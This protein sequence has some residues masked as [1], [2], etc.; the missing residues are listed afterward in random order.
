MIIND[1]ATGLLYSTGLDTDY[2]DTNSIHGST[3]RTLKSR[4]NT[5]TN[6][7]TTGAVSFIDTVLR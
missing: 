3:N 7:T 1:S 5:A 6:G 4:F 2:V